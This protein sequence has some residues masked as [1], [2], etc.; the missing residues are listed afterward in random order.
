MENAMQYLHLPWVALSFAALSLDAA[1]SCGERY[2]AFHG[3][4]FGEGAGHR[5]V[6]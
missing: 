1:M 6:A 2:V 4:A 3:R 5:R